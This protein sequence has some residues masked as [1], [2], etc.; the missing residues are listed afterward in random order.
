MLSWR[1][2]KV[3]PRVCW[4]CATRQQTHWYRRFYSGHRGLLFCWTNCV[5]D[6]HIMVC[7]QYYRFISSPWD[8]GNASISVFMFHPRGPTFVPYLVVLLL[9]L[10]WENIIQLFDY[11]GLLFGMLLVAMSALF[12]SSA[13][14]IIALFC[15]NRNRWTAECSILRRGPVPQSNTS[16]EEL[17]RFFMIFYFSINVGSV[18]SFIITPLA[19]KYF[20]YFVA[21]L[22]QV[23]C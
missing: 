9:I 23:F 13:G 18:A 6:F 16:A 11:R 14:C 19:K 2:R 7:A 10:I 17:T 15:L 3:T 12:S 8:G 20:G 4:W 5:K 22:I 21:F 1:S